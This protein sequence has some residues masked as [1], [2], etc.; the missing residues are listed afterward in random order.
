MFKAILASCVFMFCLCLA[1]KVF[2]QNGMHQHNGRWHA[3]HY[4]GF[5]RHFPSPRIAY[6]P[7]IQWYP[8][9]T[10][11]NVGPVLVSPDRRYVRMGVNMGFS[12]ITGYHTFNYSTGRS[13]WYP[14]KK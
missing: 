13:R 1:P 14:S 2:A 7:I 8:Q 9:G 11:L 3:H 12:S 4:N 6:H 5:H 10:F